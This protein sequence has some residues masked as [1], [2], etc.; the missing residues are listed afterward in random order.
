MIA[1]AKEDTH[2]FDSIF[3]WKYSRFARNQE[4]AIMYKNLLKKNGVDVRSISES[5]SDSPVA[6]LIERIIE[7]MD[8]YY[9]INLSGEVR[10][11][12]KEKATRGE[13]LGRA[14][15]GYR[16]E[17]KMYVPDENAEVVRYIF[18]RYASGI[19][20]I[21]LTHEL[22]EQGVKTAK[23]RVPSCAMV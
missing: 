3:V 14:P 7:W 11:G 15:V 8:E 5:S 17:N 21:T 23:G 1:T 4:E 18:K 10:R 6:S 22:V 2:A 19:G 12:M 13:A 20:Y 16:V 9:L